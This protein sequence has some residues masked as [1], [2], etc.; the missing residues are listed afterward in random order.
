MSGGT[1][2][3]NIMQKFDGFLESLKNYS[4]TTLKAGTKEEVSNVA[5]KMAYTAYRW[6]IYQFELDQGTKDEKLAE[7]QH[8]FLDEINTIAK[9]LASEELLTRPGDFVCDLS[10]IISELFAYSYAALPGEDGIKPS[11]ELQR[12]RYDKYTHYVMNSAPIKAMIGQLGGEQKEIDEYLE[13]RTHQHSVS[14]TVLRTLLI[15][16]AMDWNWVKEEGDRWQQQY[17]DASVYLFFYDCNSD[18]TAWAIKWVLLSAFTYNIRESEKTREAALGFVFNLID[19]MIDHGEKTMRSPERLVGE[20]LLEKVR[21]IPKL[22]LWLLAVQSGYIKRTDDDGEAIA[23]VD[24]FREAYL[25]ETKKFEDEPS[26]P[27][28]HGKSKGIQKP[29]PVNIKLSDEMRNDKFL[30]ELSDQSIDVIE[31]FGPEAAHLLNEYSCALED[32]LMQ[33]VEKC[34]EKDAKIE[35]LEDQATAMNEMLTKPELLLNYIKDFFSENGPYPTNLEEEL[36]KPYDPS[37]L[38]G[39]RYEQETKDQTK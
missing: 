25:A 8:E 26:T 23:D 38:A 27:K 4:M 19:T 6:L 11:L 30:K 14:A 31:H 15:D 21:S 3:A 10:G 33:L 35:K 5:G 2:R 37:V 7:Q 28:E 16:Y 24:A 32:A 29:V 34:K 39:W 22:D 1:D 18:F 20:Q 9:G 36:K 17:T 13:M 12:E